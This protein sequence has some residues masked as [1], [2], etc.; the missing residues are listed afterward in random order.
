MQTNL[1]YMQPASLH[2]FRDM[3]SANKV[4]SVSITG[5]EGAFYIQASTH[6]HNIVLSKDDGKVR[7]G[8]RNV[9]KALSVL[10]EIGINRAVIDITKWRPELGPL[11]RQSSSE[12]MAV[13]SEAYEASRLTRLLEARIREANNH[14]NVLHDADDVLQLLESQY[15]G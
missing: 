9:M 12:K 10:Q 2:Q 4:V 8:F 11:T 5:E 3:I 7:R 14:D 6:R 1:N 13:F 15:A